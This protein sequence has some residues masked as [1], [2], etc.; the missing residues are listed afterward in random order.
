MY[1][2]RLKGT[3]YEMGKHYGD[4][5]VVATNHFITDEMVKYNSLEWGMKKNTT[6]SDCAPR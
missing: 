5:Y 1:H 6:N 3:H 2:P 4:D